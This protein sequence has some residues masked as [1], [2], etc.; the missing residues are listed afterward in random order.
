MIEKDPHWDDLSYH[1]MADVRYNGGRLRVRFEDGSVASLDAERILPPGAGTPD[2][3]RLTFDPYEI[4]VPTA[5][6]PVETPWSTIRLLADP[7]YAAFVAQGARDYAR[8]MGERIRALRRAR[9]LTSKELAARAGIA[10]NSLSRIERGRH[11]VSLSTL[12]GLLAAMGYTYAD[13][14]PAEQVPTP[15]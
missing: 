7:A 13:L 8:R 1:R 4:A 3:S 11:E 6:G 14:T 2:W 12:G 10:P 5:T 9:G 15:A